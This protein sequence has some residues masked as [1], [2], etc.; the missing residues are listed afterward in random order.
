[1]GRVLYALTR[2]DSTTLAVF[3][4]KELA[5]DSAYKF[6]SQDILGMHKQRQSRVMMFLEDL[7][8]EYPELADLP[9]DEFV[10]SLFRKNEEVHHSADTWHIIPVDFV[11]Q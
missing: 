11:E 9:A 5:I 6:I 2:N 10:A 8:E 1:M 3:L 4:T 7:H